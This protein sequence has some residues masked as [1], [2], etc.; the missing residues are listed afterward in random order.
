MRTK[1]IEL[2]CINGL[3]K[4]IAEMVYDE[5]ERL[6]S[7]ETKQIILNMDDY[8]LVKAE[9]SGLCTGCVFY[10]DGT[11]CPDSK[12]CGWYKIYKLREDK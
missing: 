3:Q 7:T 8:E 5:I 10:E 1:F 6:Y 4:D 11:N 9:E 12:E 2:L